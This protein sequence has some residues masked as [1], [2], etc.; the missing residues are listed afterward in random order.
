MESFQPLNKHDDSASI[1]IYIYI[2]VGTTKPVHVKVCKHIK[3][4]TNKLGCLLEKFS[5]AH[6]F[7]RDHGK[8]YITVKLKNYKI[9]KILKL[10][11]RIF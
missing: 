1:Y 4:T 6:Y 2:H 7:E 3:V 11:S 8:I 9:F 5:Y 10:L